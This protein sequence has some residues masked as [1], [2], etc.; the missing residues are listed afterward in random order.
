MEGG[1]EDRRGQGRGGGGEGAERGWRRGGLRDLRGESHTSRGC[2]F[3][4]GRSREITGDYR[5]SREI[6]SPP[7]GVRLKTCPHKT[8]SPRNSAAVAAA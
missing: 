2:A 1:V 6:T 5:I 3:E 8:P 7:E 4:A